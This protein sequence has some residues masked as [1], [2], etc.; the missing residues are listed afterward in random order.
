MYPAVVTLI[1][2][3]LFPRQVNG[4]VIEKDGTKVGSELIGQKFDDE[5]YFWGR[6]SATTPE[7]NGASSSGSNLGPTNPDQIKNVKDRIEALRRAHPEKGDAP[8]PADLVTA[9]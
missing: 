4:S 7:Y 3:G 2:Q 9:S 8:V 6:P 1:G 5:R